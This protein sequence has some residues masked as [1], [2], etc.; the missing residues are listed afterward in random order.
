MCVDIVLFVVLMAVE[1]KTKKGTFWLVQFMQI[2]SS[3]SLSRVD[4]YVIVRLL[5][6]GVL[7]V[8]S[9]VLWVVAGFQVGLQESKNILT[10]VSAPHDF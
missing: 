10:T 9:A 4:L 8:T 2:L 1:V 6:G 5:V 3:G 7:M